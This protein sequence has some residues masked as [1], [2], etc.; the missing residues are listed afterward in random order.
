M[1]GVEVEAYLQAV[2]AWV[3]RA[4]GRQSP[5]FPYDRLAWPK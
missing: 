1:E 3:I 5:A 2:N 4:P